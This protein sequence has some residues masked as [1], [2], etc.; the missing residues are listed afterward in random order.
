MESH[1][2]SDARSGQIGDIQ[3]NNEDETPFEGVEIKHKI[4]ITSELVRHAFSKLMLH[5]TDRY[6]I[7][8]T[9]NMD[10]ADWDAINME[11]DKIE[12]RHGC[13]V[14]VNGVYSTLRYYLRL[15]KDPAEFVERYVELLKSDEN[16]KYPHRLAWNELNTN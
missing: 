16:V 8:T 1:T 5:R 6:Y 4:V 15:L 7:L 3:I 13:Q 14:I 12:H 2:S 11:I 9:A 10:S